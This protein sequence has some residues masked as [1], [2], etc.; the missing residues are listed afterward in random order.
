M[1]CACLENF[2]KK[3]LSPKICVEIV[4]KIFKVYKSVLLLLFK[5]KCVILKKNILFVICTKCACFKF[6]EKIL[7]G[8]MCLEIET[9]TTCYIHEMCVFREF[10]EKKSKSQNLC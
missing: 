6:S 9:Y 10:S 1:K 3:N 7:S 8:K 2:L 5:R 4:L